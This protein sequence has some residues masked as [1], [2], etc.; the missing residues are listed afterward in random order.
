MAKPK[1]QKKKRKASGADAP[2]A[3]WR[4]PEPSKG[5]E[6][7]PIQDYLPEIIRRKARRDVMARIRA[8]PSAN[9]DPE[10]V[11]TAVRETVK[12]YA[13]E[14]FEIHK[15]YMDR[16]RRLPNA[17]SDQDIR[18]MDFIDAKDMPR[19]RPGENIKAY[20]SELE[21]AGLLAYAVVPCFPDGVLRLDGNRYIL[22]HVDC[23][24]EGAMRT[25]V[26]IA[27]YQCSDEDPGH[28][29][30]STACAVAIRMK[31]CGD[32]ALDLSYE[33][34]E[35]GLVLPSDTMMLIPPSELQWTAEWLDLWQSCGIQHALDIEEQARIHEE[36]FHVTFAR[37]FA[38]A[39][40]TTNYMLSK[41]RPT[42][43]RPAKE[44]RH[45]ASMDDDA[46]GDGGRAAMRP[47]ARRE[48]VVGPI[49]IISERPPKPADRKS[50]RKYCTAAWSVRGHTRTY[51]SGKIAYVQPHVNHR[52]SLRRDDGVQPNRIRISSGKEEMA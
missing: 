32:T 43:V 8:N 14:F 2:L 41:H 27:L 49:R 18:S 22:F 15:D 17:L 26:R 1:K 24:D 3:Q 34:Q 37:S 30:R 46:H 52:R 50:I 9:R 51:K 42:I 7:K 33:F 28:L 35:Q 4:R 11:E 25:H 38:E 44:P 45:E 19:D 47:P 20:L 21:R 31:G 36:P 39:V 6:G 16:L 12:R 40:I 48:R 10:A 23:V 29:F 13:K 5:L